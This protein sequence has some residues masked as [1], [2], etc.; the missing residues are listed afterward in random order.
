ML[1]EYV[2][3]DLHSTQLTIHRIIIDEAHKVHRV[4]GRYTIEQLDDGFY[5][6]LGPDSHVCVEAGSGS[7]MFARMA[8]V[9]GAKAYV[10]D[11]QRLPQIFMAGKKTDR[12]DAKKLADYLKMHL[13]SGDRHDG[14]AEVYVA[15]ED[16]QI[17]RVLI[18]QYQRA[19]ADMTAIVN[20]MYAI[21]RQYLI[22]VDKGKLIDQLDACLAHQRANKYLASIVQRERAKYEALEKERQ[23]LRLQIE[24]LGVLRYSEQIRL[25]IGINGISVF[26]AACI[27]ADIITIDRFPSAKHLTSYL[28][29]A[30]KVDASN[31]TVHIGRLNKAGRHTAFGV[32]LQSV[33]HLK[34][35]NPFILRY[36]KHAV[37]KSRNKI[38]AA[39]VGRTIRQIFY[40]LKN[41]EPN[42]FLNT[43]NF[44][45]KNRQVEKILLARKSA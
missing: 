14:F 29:A 25:L 12:V 26:G 17:M 44:A 18:S 30:P 20:N 27:M 33:N 34:S 13:E 7:H 15:D 5:P 36:T 6:T 45:S 11:P 38:R 37:G 2:G 42:R 3:V 28:R 21:F 40:I 24:E 31:K 43:V 32:L 4:N 39:A 22:P 19:T 23:E 8:K 41:Q 9:L 1:R 10:V 35:S 16:T